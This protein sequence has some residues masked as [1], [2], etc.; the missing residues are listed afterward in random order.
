MCGSFTQNL[1]AEQSNG[2]RDCLNKRKVAM[3]FAMPI[4]TMTATFVM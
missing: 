2:L 3:P 4:I 1:K